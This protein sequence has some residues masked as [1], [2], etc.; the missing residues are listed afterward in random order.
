MLLSLVGTRFG[1]NEL[2]RRGR[3]LFVR[4]DLPDGPIE[5]V[6]AIVTHERTGEAQ[7]RRW[8]LGVKVHQMADTDTEQLTAYLERRATGEPVVISE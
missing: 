1:E 3:L 6:V 4:I 5:S 8:L 7:R 2:T